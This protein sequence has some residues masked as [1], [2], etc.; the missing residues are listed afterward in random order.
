[1]NGLQ[2]SR[3]IF[4]YF[5]E[6]TPSGDERSILV[7]VI[8]TGNPVVRDAVIKATNSQNKMP[9]ASLRATDPIHHQIEDLF[10]QYD[11]Y[12]DRRK[13]FYKDQGKAIDKIV[14]VTALVQ[15]VVSIVQQRPDDG[16]ARPSDYIK[17][18][19]RF[20]S[21]FREDKLPLGVYLTCVSLMRRVDAFPDVVSLERGEAR[22]VKFYVAAYLTCALTKQLD[23]TPE[24]VLNIDVRSID[25]AVIRDC[26]VR[27]WKKYEELGKSDTVA[28]GP[29]LLKHLRTEI[30]RRYSRRP[31]RR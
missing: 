26:Y 22:N 25:D 29:D 6:G 24:Q 23:P 20:E 13:G 14:S 10:K 11:L 17:D 30:R 8:E 12:Y 4:N 28:R 9:P 15:A 1:M 31:K 16:R 27:V 21:I 5:S 2:T 19:Q 3:E 18:D 7:K